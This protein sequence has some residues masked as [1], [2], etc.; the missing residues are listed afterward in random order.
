MPNLNMGVRGRR[1]AWLPA[2]A[3]VAALSGC[4]KNEADIFPPGLIP[5][6][7]DN[8]AAFPAGPGCPQGLGV[9]PRARQVDNYWVGNGKGYLA[10][11]LQQVYQAMGEWQLSAER[12]PGGVTQPP[13]LIAANVEPEYPLSFLIHHLNEVTLLKLN[14]WFDIT[15]R[16]GYL[17]GTP[18]KPVEAADPKVDPTIADATKT[19]II[20]A[21]HK[22][23]DGTTHIQVLTGSVMAYEPPGCPGVTAIEMIRHSQNDDPGGQSKVAYDAA[24]WTAFYFYGLLWRLENPTANIATLPEDPRVFYGYTCT[25]Q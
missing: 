17:D 7:A 12:Q 9:I 21:R 23:T 1:A 10:Y 20:G 19:R 16:Y 24:C 25:P 3:A 8:L 18:A 11:P 14:V 6:D 22:K 13:N 4:L 5:I 2:V 15:W